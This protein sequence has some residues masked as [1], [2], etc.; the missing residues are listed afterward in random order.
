MDS[1]NQRLRWPRGSAS[2]FLVCS[3]CWRHSLL[4]SILQ[5]PGNVV[6]PRPTFTSD[7]FA[8]RQR[9][10][11]SCMYRVCAMWQIFYLVL[12]KIRGKFKAWSLLSKRVLPNGT[13]ETKTYEKLTKTAEFRVCLIAR[14][15]CPS[16]EIRAWSRWKK[17]R[18]PILTPSSLIQDK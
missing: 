17:K 10:T 13:S 16:V 4:L 8:K 2:P 9:L 12:W 1:W 3:K 5:T 14:L 7:S 15:K 18:L 11:A 6:G